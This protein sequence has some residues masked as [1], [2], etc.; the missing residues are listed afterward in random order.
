MHICKREDIKIEKRTFLIYISYKIPYYIQKL[1]ISSVNYH[2][3]HSLLFD[4]VCEGCGGGIDG[5]KEKTHIQ[6]L[7]H[8]RIRNNAHCLGTKQKLKFSKKAAFVR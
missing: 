6:F 2:I 3:E 7:R 1:L 8:N 5:D 4:V